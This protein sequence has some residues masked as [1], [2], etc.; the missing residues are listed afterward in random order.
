MN[1]SV[2]PVVST[3][4]NDHCSKVPA[5]V[6]GPIEV[7]ISHVKYAGSPEEYTRSAPP[8][9]APENPTTSLVLF[10]KVRVAVVKSNVP[11]PAIAMEA[12]LSL[13]K[14]PPLKV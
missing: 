3:G 12:E 1:T 10:T 14:N 13:M 11:T 5:P 4:N 7:V 8:T 2:P 6:N 9:P